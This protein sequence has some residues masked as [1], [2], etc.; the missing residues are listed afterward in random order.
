M[1]VGAGL[2]MRSFSV[3]C[4]RIGFLASLDHLQPPG[5][6]VELRRLVR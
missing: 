5:A 2:L 1:L 3:S 4:A 6:V